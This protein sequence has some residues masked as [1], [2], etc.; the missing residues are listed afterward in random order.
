MSELRLIVDELETIVAKKYWP[1]P[2]Y[3]DLLYS[4]I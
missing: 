2:S 3:A 4:V 1:L